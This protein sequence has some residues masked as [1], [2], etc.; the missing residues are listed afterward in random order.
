MVAASG[1]Y[2][3]LVAAIA[4]VACCDIAMGLTFQLLPLLME[5]Q[6]IPAWIMGVNTAMGPIGILMAGPVLPRLISRFG[7]KPLVAAVLAVLIATLLAFKLAPSIWLWFPIRFIFGIA[8]GTL[9]TVSEA[10]VLTFASDGNRGRVMGLYT[11]VLALT[12]SVGPLILPFTGIDGWMPWLIAIVCIAAS[13]LPMALVQVSDAAFRQTHGG[14]FF[15]FIGRAPLLLFAVGTVTLFDS[16]FI[17]FFTIFGLRHGL[18][19]DVASRILGA[20]IIGNTLMFYPMGLLADRWSRIGVIVLTA[21]L[22]ILLSLSLI[23]VIDTWAIW[24]VVILLSSCAFGVYVVALAVMGDA[25]K[26]P[27]VV[28]GSA[29]FA[30]MWGVGGLIG[31]PIAGGAIDAFGINALPFTLAA[32]YAILL[33]GLALNNGRL[34]RRPLVA[35][36]GMTPRSFGYAAGIAFAAAGAACWSLGGA[37]VRLT[38]RIDVWQIVFYRSLTVLLCMGFWLAIRFGTSLPALM[39]SAGSNAVIAGIA[40]AAAGLSFMASLFYTTV[41]QAIFMVGITPFLSAILGFWIL[42]ERIPGITWLAMTVALIGMGLIFQSAGGGGAFMGTVLAIFSAFCFSCYAV[43]LRWGHK[44]EMSVALIWNALFLIVIAGF[45][46]LLPT[47]LR[48]GTGL[49]HF[50]IG[51][52]NF[53]STFVMGAVQLTLGLILFTVGSR[54]VPAAQLSLIALV[55]P[56]LSPLWAWLA[57]KELPPIWTFIGGAVILCAIVIQALFSASK[58]SRNARHRRTA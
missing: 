13:A 55:E 1:R 15:R 37:L 17:S 10:W 26:G 42:R 34:V 9:F 3:N 49:T 52:G 46:I 16:V 45:V 25:F 5:R 27:D 19:L 31:P 32:F 36:A 29:A 20:G 40:I 43:L 21:S 24:P 41:A 12:F 58:E 35:Q 7:S 57:A 30:A 50:A 2:G 28:A 48:T 51:W 56:T 14:G 38:E 18:E 53:A 11:S 44:T 6:G 33:T 8:V 39:I 23:L 22:T 4:T 47:G 54:S